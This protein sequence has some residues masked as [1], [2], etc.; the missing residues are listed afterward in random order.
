MARS[1]DRACRT[2]EAR[3]RASVAAP[4]DGRDGAAGLRPVRLQL[5]RLCGCGVRA[6]GSAPESLRARRQG[7]RPHAEVS[8]RGARQRAGGRSCRKDCARCRAGGRRHAGFAGRSRVPFAQALEQA[9][10]GERD[11]ARRLR[12]DG[13]RDRLQGRRLVRGVSHERSGPGSSGDRRAG[14]IARHPQSATDRCA[15][16]SR[17]PSRSAPRRTRCSS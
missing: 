3:R 16:C 17:T 6:K 9:G 4:D 2:H 15:T 5:L 12:S 7:N 13:D 1:D 14:C 11:V 10:I 8:V